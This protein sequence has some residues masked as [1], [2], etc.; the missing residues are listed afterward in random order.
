MNDFRSTCS[1]GTLSK[2]EKNSL[3]S[4]PA[5]LGS[6]DL[7]KR[8]AAYAA[9]A[10]A[11][12]CL[13][14]ASPDAEAKVVYSPAHIVID[15]GMKF[16]LDVNHD[17]VVDFV[18]SN[19]GSTYIQFFGVIPQ[20]HANAVVDE[21]FC[22]SSN[23]QPRNAPAALPSGQEI[24]KQLNFRPYGQCMRSFVYY[25]TQGH[26]QHVT[27][28]YL[29][30]AMRI[31]GQIHYGWARLSTSRVLNF[32]AVLTGYAYETDPGKPV[33]AG[34][35]GQGARDAKSSAPASQPVESGLSLGELTLGTVRPSQ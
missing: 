24:G 21:G 28:K 11:G 29:G 15:Q 23:L 14:S 30:L 1:E 33:V 13:L 22:I 16:D 27:N 10:V 6:A 8:I 5:R 20:D 7:E 12:A 2:I 25:D 3:P 18:F 34:D 31:D 17:G 35:E 4:N 26:W 19:G 32:Q 9:A